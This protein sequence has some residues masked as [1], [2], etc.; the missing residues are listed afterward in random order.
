MEFILNFLIL[1][2]LLIQSTYSISFNLPVST[3]KCLKEEIHKV[4]SLFFS[5][6][7]ELLKNVVVVFDCKQIENVS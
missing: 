4:K 1:S 6:A 3:K 7:T 2:L 5:Y